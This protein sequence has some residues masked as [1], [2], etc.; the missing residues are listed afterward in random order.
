VFTEQQ[1]K[2]LKEGYPNKFIGT[3]LGY[4][5]EKLGAYLNRPSRKERELSW[6]IKN[7]ADVERY[8]RIHYL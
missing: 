6:E 2:W 4:W 1:N 5:F 8:Q 3:G 7:H